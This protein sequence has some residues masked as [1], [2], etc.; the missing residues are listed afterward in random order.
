M[1]S[2][3]GAVVGISMIA[4]SIAVVWQLPNSNSL[5]GSLSKPLIDSGLLRNQPLPPPPSPL[6]TC[7]LW[8]FDPYGGQGKID[9][10]SD[11]ECTDHNFTFLGDP[12]IKC[13]QYDTQLHKNGFRW[14]SPL[15]GNFMS[16]VPSAGYLSNCKTMPVPGGIP[17]E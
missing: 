12:G 17:G 9:L 15:T 2:H 16:C 3:L 6:C 1:K 5:V 8:A 14:G 7:S 10:Y 11:S 13:E 4:A